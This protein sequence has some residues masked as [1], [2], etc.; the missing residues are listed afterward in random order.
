MSQRV[1][2][3]EG[4]ERIR[5]KIEHNEM[6]RQVHVEVSAVLREAPGVDMSQATLSGDPRELRG[7]PVVGRGI[8]G[9]S[10]GT[11]PTSGLERM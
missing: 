1:R 8:G 10:P 7:I 3:V 4:V 11:S 5:R 9:V 2:V 6:L